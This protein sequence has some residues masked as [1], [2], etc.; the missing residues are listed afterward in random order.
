MTDAILELSAQIWTAQQ[1]KTLLY[2]IGLV[3]LLPQ[4]LF[5][6]SYTAGECL[7]KSSQLLFSHIVIFGLCL[8]EFHEPPIPFWK[9][10][11]NQE[12]KDFEQM[13]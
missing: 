5:P 8:P 13:F 4:Q 12:E 6:L 1:F 2:A 3:H 11:L 10:Y 9:E 7:Q